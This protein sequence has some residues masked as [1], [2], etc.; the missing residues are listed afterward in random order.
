MKLLTKII[1]IAIAIL[2]AAGAVL[3]GLHF[4]DYQYIDGEGEDYILFSEKLHGQYW[5]A[6]DD[7]LFIGDKIFD[8]DRLPTFSSIEEMIWNI[9]LGWFSE[10]EMAAIVDLRGDQGSKIPIVD[11]EDLMVPVYFDALS[12]GDERYVFDHIHYNWCFEGDHIGFV[13]RNDNKTLLLSRISQNSYDAKA[14]EAQTNEGRVVEHNGMTYYIIPKA[15]WQ[16]RT[17]YYWEQ[18][19]RYYSAGILLSDVNDADSPQLL[20][21][22]VFKEYSHYTDWLVGGAAVILAAAAIAIP[23]VLKKKRK[24]AVQSPE[25]DENP[26]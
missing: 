14:K 16:G 24:T 2:V 17:A 23:L 25:N 18:N 10:E 3:A 9:R 13:Y 11:L 19:G 8:Y 20:G 7:P 22:L 5:P 21:Q 15:D 1:I 6:L 4:I 12:L 26:G